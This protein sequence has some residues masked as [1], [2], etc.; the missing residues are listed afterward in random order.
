MN[1]LLTTFHRN[2]MRGIIWRRPNKN[3]SLAYRKLCR[4]ICGN[5]RRL[6]MKTSAA[7]TL[8]ISG[9]LKG[10]DNLAA[11]SYLG[12]PPLNLQDNLLMSSFSDKPGFFK[13]R[14]FTHSLKSF[15]SIPCRSDTGCGIDWRWFPAT[16]ATPTQVGLFL[17]LLLGLSP[18]QA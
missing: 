13:R 12:P 10:G 11:S 2:T 7:P 5:S 4:Q 6:V 17:R 15:R 8:F 3:H 16:A 18:C 14:L 9:V 1:A